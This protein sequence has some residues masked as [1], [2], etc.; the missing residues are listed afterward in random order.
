M[1]IELIIVTCE[2]SY[3]NCLLQKHYG[4]HYISH[5]NGDFIL[6]HACLSKV[7]RTLGS[8]T[9]L[10]L[11]NI[12]LPSSFLKYEM[13]LYEYCEKVG[14]RLFALKKMG[15]MCFLEIDLQSIK[16]FIFFRH[17]S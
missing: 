6:V 3:M 10:I 12:F 9:C 15:N 11:A 7:R 8:F 5:V 2:M 13:P 16:A 1:I 17:A 4:A 14:Q